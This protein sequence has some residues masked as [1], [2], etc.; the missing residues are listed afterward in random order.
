MK[1]HDEG[2]EGHE[3]HEIMRAMKAE[4]RFGHVWSNALMLDID[5]A[6]YLSEQRR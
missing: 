6:I 3:D 1:D 5:R 4:G 2:H